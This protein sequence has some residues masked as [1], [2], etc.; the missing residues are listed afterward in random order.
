MASK[1]EVIPPK[2][3]KIGRPSNYDPE[4]ATEICKL[5]AEG[6]S[7]NEISKMDGLPCLTAIYNWLRAEPSFASNYAR[8]KEDS[9][10]TFAAMMIDAVN[11]P[12][13]DALAVNVARLKLDAYKWIA[14]K[15]KPR[16]YGDRVAAELTGKDGGPIQTMSVTLDAGE[17]T[18]DARELLRQSL[19]SLRTADE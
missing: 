14:C 11:V 7:L 10:D 18:P 15:L 5:L 12:F 16:S 1:V 17:L 9:A 2:K 4:I 3:K 6:K 13:E 8:A 19:M